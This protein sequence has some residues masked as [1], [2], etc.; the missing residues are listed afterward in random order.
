[1]KLGKTYIGK[2]GAKRT[3]LYY[4]DCGRFIFVRCVYIDGKEII[5]AFDKH[6]YLFKD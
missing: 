4:S 6:H 5:K 1:M 3:P 2:T